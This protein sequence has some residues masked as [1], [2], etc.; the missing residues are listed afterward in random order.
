M[1]C[2]LIVTR[3]AEADLEGIVGYLV[4][5]LA[6]PRAAAA[7]LDEIEAR[8]DQME[9]NPLVYPCCRQKLLAAGGYR[10]VVIGRYLLIYHVDGSRVCVDRFFH[11]LQDYADKV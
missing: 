6:N 4:E 7:L 1:T 11:D 3:R 8:Y 10:K 2:E 9:R 5:K